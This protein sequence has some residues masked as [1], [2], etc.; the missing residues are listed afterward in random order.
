MREQKYHL[1]RKRQADLRALL[2]GLVCLYL[3]YLGFS[4]AFQEGGD[5]SQPLRLLIGGVF[6]LGALVFGLYTLR[7]YRAALAAA[8]LTQEEREGIP[9]DRKSVV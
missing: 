3:G 6:A 4:L 5:L 7:Q 9:G 2:R 8:E 1:I